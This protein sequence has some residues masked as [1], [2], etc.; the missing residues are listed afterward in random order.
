MYTEADL[1]AAIDEGILA[2][3]DANA[4]RDFVARKTS[5]NPV[6][7]ENFRLLTGFNDIFVAIAATLF[8][9]A[10]GWLGSEFHPAVGGGL[11]AVVAL[12]LSAYFTG[13]RRMALPSIVLVLAFI[14]GTFLLA[15]FGVSEDIRSASDPLMFAQFGFA[16]LAAF[17]AA[18]VHWRLFRVPITAAVA[19][20][21][22]VGATFLGY[23]A[24]TDE[25]PIGLL[26]LGGL[27]VFAV[28][29]WWDMRDPLRQSTHSDVAFWLH[30][31]AAPLMVHPVFEVIGALDNS[32][33]TATAFLVIGL[34]FVITF[35]A[36][37]I[38][39]RALMV[40]S[41]VYVL[42]AIASLFKASGEVEIGFAVAGMVIGCALL[43]LSAFWQTAR[44]AVVARLP[45]RLREL[46]PVLHRNEQR[47]GYDG[48][49]AC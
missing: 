40:S 13:V 18:G 14:A 16:T 21:V 19:A 3:E 33:E 11:V 17:V 10:L 8:L 44:A 39:R 9:V 46:L 6:D 5:K 15:L 31:V 2:P 1:D 38:D 45:A 22:V 30:L 49:S 41:L 37:A 42:Y 4:F 43:F 24:A 36:L 20:G 23:A 25:F 35:V 47:N 26:G 29:M 32:P 27:T 34:Y 28:A 7:E 12:K 48:V